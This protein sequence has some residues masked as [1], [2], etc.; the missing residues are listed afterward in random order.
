VVGGWKATRKTSEDLP[1]GFL[2]TRGIL[3]QGEMGMLIAAYSF[4]R[5]LMSPVSFNAAIIVVVA[6]TIITPIL[7][8]IASAEWRR[9]EIAVEPSFNSSLS[10]RGRGRLGRK[11]EAVR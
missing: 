9:G 8:K 6:L 7:M 1:R 3:P 5:G 4:S 2:A 10:V 11:E